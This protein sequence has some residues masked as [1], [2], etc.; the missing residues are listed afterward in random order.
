MD[1]RKAGRKK[2]VCFFLPGILHSSALFESLTQVAKVL[3]IGKIS[4]SRKSHKSCWWSSS[5]RHDRAELSNP[6]L[7]L[8]ESKSGLI[9]HCQH[10]RSFWKALKCTNKKA[11]CAILMISSN[12]MRIW[13]NA[14][15]A[16]VEIGCLDI[17]QVHKYDYYM[18][19]RLWMDGV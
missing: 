2:E 18:L 1:K 16:Y 17:H 14:N 4:Q 11:I 7:G 8:L 9:E 13:K 12:A 3:K 15:L 10:L 19:S 5:W 6:I